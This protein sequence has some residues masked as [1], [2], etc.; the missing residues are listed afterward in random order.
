MVPKATEDIVNV[1]PQLRNSTLHPRCVPGDHQL[2]EQCD[3]SAE[4]KRAVGFT[5]S[6]RKVYVVFVRAVTIYLASLILGLRAKLSKSVSQVSLNI[7]MYMLKIGHPLSECRVVGC[8][9]VVEE[10]AALTK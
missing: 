3:R 9:T 4:F 2:R 10:C 5:E 1:G 8:L 7:R 6:T